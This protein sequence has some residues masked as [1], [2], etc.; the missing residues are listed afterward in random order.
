MRTTFIIGV[1]NAQEIHQAQMIPTFYVAE[2]KERIINYLG[3]RHCKYEEDND[4]LVI[5]VD[6]AL[7][8]DNRIELSKLVREECSDV[9]YLWFFEGEN[10]RETLETECDNNYVYSKLS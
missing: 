7:S 4:V 6:E 1:L 10:V 5:E 8:Q 9:L 2:A 3:K